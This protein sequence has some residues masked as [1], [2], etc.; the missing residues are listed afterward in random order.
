MTLFDVAQRL[1]G[2]IQER[3]GAV[4]HPFIVWCHESTTMGA[5]AD[6][7]PWCSSFVNRLAWLLRLPR[8]KS[9][10]ARSWLDIGE[11]I[12]LEDARPGYD[13]VVFTRGSSPTSGHVAIF[14]GL[15]GNTV[16]V[17]GGNQSNAVTL[18]AFPRDSVIG[19]RR[20]KAV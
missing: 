12:R 19:V 14:A 10:A 16:R 2:E 1:V 15:E 9:A 6:E 17:V 8:S 13:V 5:A 11:S 18:A 4:D 20:L 3:P 7:I